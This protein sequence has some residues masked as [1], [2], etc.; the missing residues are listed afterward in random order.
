MSAGAA[1]RIDKLLWYLRLAPSRGTAQ[2]WALAGHIRVGG[3]RVTKAAHAVR[4]GDVL[5]LPLFGG[6]R[7]I[8][9]IALPHRRGPAS[10]ARACYSELGRPSESDSQQGEMIDAA[11]PAALGG[12]GV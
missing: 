10:E 6:V 1:L 5:T 9:I 2:Q 3:Q 4:S 11:A 8:S 12:T 7:V